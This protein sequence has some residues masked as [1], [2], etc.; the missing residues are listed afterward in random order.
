MYLITCDRCGRE[1][2]MDVTSVRDH[3]KEFHPKL[4]KAYDKYFGDKD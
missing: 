3:I 4:L 2:D 1:I